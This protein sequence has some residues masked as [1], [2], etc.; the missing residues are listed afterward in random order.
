MLAHALA[1][2]SEAAERYAEL[3]DQMA[4]HNNQEV[5]A[6]FRKLGDIE[7]LHAENIR[8]QAAGYELPR[9]SL[10]GYR[11]GSRESP[12]ALDP[13]EVHYLITPREAV[14]LALRHERQAAEFYGRI[15]RG[16]ASQEVRKLAKGYE[17]EEKE[18]VRLLTEW[19]KRYPE[20][21]C[22]RDDDPDPPMEQE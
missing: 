6:L 2:E 13:G 22:D 5:A 19:L 14:K 20:T 3:A 11:W 1:M 9:I 18:H 7:R 16:S 17:E 8:R 4:V 12:E 10:G 21:G 15:A